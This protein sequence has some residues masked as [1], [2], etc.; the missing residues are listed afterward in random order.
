MLRLKPM[1]ITDSIQLNSSVLIYSMKKSP[2]RRPFAYL[3]VAGR[4]GAQSVRWQS[5]LARVK[6]RANFW[7]KRESSRACVT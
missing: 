5:E 7:A 3:Q 4:T 1:A 6:A 2:K